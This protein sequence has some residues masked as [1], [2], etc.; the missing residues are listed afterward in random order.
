M[1][2]IIGPDA[3]VDSFLVV[4][5]AGAGRWTT[6]LG[7]FDWD[8]TFAGDLLA[9][10]A[11]AAC[12]EAPGLVLQSVQAQLLAPGSAGARATLQT[13]R[14]DA[15]AAAARIRVRLESDGA[16]L[17]E[18]VARLAAPQRGVT[19]AGERPIPIAPPESLPSDVELARNDGWPARYLAP[20]E[21][22][23]AEPSAFPFAAVADGAPAHWSGWLRPRAPL[24]D[25]VALH[26]A[27]LV[28]ASDYRSHWGVEVRIG[29]D[30]FAK[31]GYTGVD[32]T[33]WVHASI[34][35]TDWWRFDTRSE[36]CRDGRALVERAVWSR[37]GVRVATV[38]QAGVVEAR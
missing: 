26:A 16:A 28:F 24:G 11:L 13:Q 8:A 22:R 4:E 12:R 3:P 21:F 37:D 29:D 6:S 34:P 7:D 32:H 33:L 23:R 30:A 9:R 10:A 17:V 18:L 25:D 1:T 35:W 38:A 2:P 31:C 19:Y 20:I 5:P 15:S 36:V 14:L 27:A